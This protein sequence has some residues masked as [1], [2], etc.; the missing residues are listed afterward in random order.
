ML[1]IHAQGIHTPPVSTA[2]NAMGH[3]PCPSYSSLS[4]GS[5]LVRFFR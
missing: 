4:T 2:E 1:F 3:R 5:V